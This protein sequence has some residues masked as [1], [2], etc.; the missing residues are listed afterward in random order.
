MDIV[1]IRDLQV[2]AVVGIYEWERKVRQPVLINLD[3][4]HDN[5]VPAK[6]RNI[7]DALNYKAVA[8]RIC[9]LVVDQK[10]ELL[11]TMAEEI[12]LVLQHE[13]AVPWM[14]ISCAKP[15]VLTHVREVGVTIER[16]VRGEK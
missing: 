4:G 13:F 9:N 2:E 3:M 14:R 15:T 5:S 10:F 7:E 8:D 6:S 11:E 1:F 16:G 12:A